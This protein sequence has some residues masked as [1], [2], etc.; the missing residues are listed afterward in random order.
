MRADTLLFGRVTYEM[1]QEAWRRPETGAWSDWMTDGDRGDAV[2][3]LKAQPGD[4]LFVG[5][6]T[7]PL[8]LADLGLIDEY[9][10][11][12]NPIIAGHGPRLLDGLHDRVELELI[13]RHEFR[14]GAVT[15]RYRPA[16]AALTSP[17]FYV[18]GRLVGSATNRAPGVRRRV[19]GTLSLSAGPHRTNRPTAARLRRAVEQAGEP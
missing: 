12:V 11:L 3:R 8:A 7:L 19:L 13:G 1:M 6:A 5:G 10:F 16:G 4:N 15:M 9:E 17:G 2:R 14:S 18:V